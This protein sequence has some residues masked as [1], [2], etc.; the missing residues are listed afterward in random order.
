M[1]A[2]NWMVGDLVLVVAGQLAAL[3]L[4]ATWAHF[5]WKA[6]QS[7]VSS[8]FA[9]I[10]ETTAAM[11]ADMADARKE[12]MLGVAALKEAD[13]GLASQLETANRGIDGLVRTGGDELAALGRKVDSGGA[14]LGRRLAVVV[15]RAEEIA[16]RI[17]TATPANRSR[18]ADSRQWTRPPIELQA[19]PT[20]PADGTRD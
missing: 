7:A 19:A 17:H 3:V 15:T 13:Q 6:A 18:P 5:R 11:A 20:R 4:F 8:R 12:I 16:N 9:E 1:Q 14:E 2:T 10:G